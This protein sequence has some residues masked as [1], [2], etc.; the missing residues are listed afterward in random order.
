MNQ[1]EFRIENFEESFVI[2]FGG[3]LSRINAYTLASTLVNIADAAKAANA[4]INPGYDIE[5]V[6]EA[7]GGG[8]FKAKIRSVY[9]G[10]AN[11]FST[12][13]LT[14]I[15]LGVIAS[16]IYQHTLAPDTSVKVNVGNNDVIIEQG[17]NKIIIPRIIH[18]AVQKVEKSPQFRQG[19]GQAMRAVE[20]DKEITSIGFSK[21]M[22]DKEP[23]LHIPRENLHLLSS[24][25][26]EPDGETRELIEVTDV[27]ILRAILERSRRRWEFVW[28]GMRISAPVTDN[29]FYDDFFAHKIT[30]A[31]GDRLRIRLKIRQRRSPDIGIYINDSYEVIEVLQ[32]SSRSTQARL[33]FTKGEDSLSKRIKRKFDFE[34]SSS[35]ASS[36]STSTILS[37]PE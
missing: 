7:L 4:A 21:S 24:Y 2:H 17:D 22:S 23:I 16:F 18:D 3:M 27:E 33:N 26:G 8:S 36:T 12:Q 29:I 25:M 15:V 35:D 31:P 19:I 37:L 28:N 34:D 1:G 30:I 9:R 32:H 10:A 20:E 5:I 6:V 14:A 11:L 13:K